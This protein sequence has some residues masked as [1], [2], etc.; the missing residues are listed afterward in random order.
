MT[1]KSTASTRYIMS[2]ALFTAGMYW[3]PLVKNLQGYWI[4]VPVQVGPPSCL[5]IGQWAIE[6]ADEYPRTE[7]IGMDLAPIQS[8]E[9][10]LN[11]EFRVGDVTNELVEFDD[12][13]V[14]LVHSRYACWN[15]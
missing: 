15:V 5:R 10:P 13:S 12:G 11:C 14:D 6:V 1:T 9:V 8:E 2:L 7:V 4:L 3:R